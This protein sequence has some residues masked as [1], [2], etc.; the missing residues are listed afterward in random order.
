MDFITTFDFRN[1]S[2]EQFSRCLV[3]N[4]LFVP[5]FELTK[6]YPSWQ[7]IAY[8]GP[9]AVPGRFRYVIAD[10]N[11]DGKPI[12]SE[13]W[14]YIGVNGKMCADFSG[15]TAYETASVDETIALVDQIRQRNKV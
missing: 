15:W 7:L 4:G 6:Q 9:S 1:L 3:N 8:A 11:D 2:L 13:A 5:S 12:V 14:V 10:I